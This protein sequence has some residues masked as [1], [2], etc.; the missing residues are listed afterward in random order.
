MC[1]CQFFSHQSS[2]SIAFYNFKW[3]LYIGYVCWTCGQKTTSSANIL[4]IPSILVLHSIAILWV[5]QRVNN[6]FNKCKWF[7][8]V[9]KR[10]STP[11][12][13]AKH[14]L[15]NL[16]TKK[17]KGPLLNETMQNEHSRP[18]KMT[19]VHE[20]YRD[21]RAWEPEEQQHALTNI[22]TKVRQLHN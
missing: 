6:L 21:L 17:E 3:P 4:M 10:Q 7:Q 16:S 15:M 11:T 13:I 22:K 5:K 18:N 20:N 1:Q 2:T 8:S 9:N 19:G 12:Q 14:R